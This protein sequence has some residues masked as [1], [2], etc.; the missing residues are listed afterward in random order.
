MKSNIGHTSAAAGVAGVIKMVL[1]LQHG[2]LPKTLHLG[3]PSRHVDWSAGAVELLREARP[4]R[5]NG[6][7][8]R[9]GVSAFGVSGTN[10]HVILEEAPGL[11]EPG[12][13]EVGDSASLDGEGGWCVWAFAELGVLPLLVS[14]KSEV[15]LGAQAQRLGARLRKDPELASLDVAF[16]LV[17]GRAQLER[18]AVVVGGDRERL[19]AG[20]DA[21]ACDKPVEGLV[22]GVARD[23]GG[24]VFVFSGQG[25]QWGGMALGLWESSAVF[26]AE[27]DAC[28][29]AF[30]PYLGF[31][32]EDVLRGREGASVFERVDVLQPAL[33]AVMV[34]LAAL[35]RSCG[36][37]PGAVVGHSQ[38]EIAAAYV[39]GGLSLEDAACVVALRGRALAD[40]LSGRGGMVSVAL[41]VDEVGS[42][43]EP[44]GERVAL[45]AVNGPSSVVISGEP[46]AL[47]E[48]LLLCETRGLRAKQ[49]PVDYASHSR[50]V[51]VI[52]GRLEE[53]LA[54]DQPALW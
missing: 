33:F 29:R 32:L 50:Q 2:V 46:E 38:G 42:L 12:P 14:A 15:A 28:V 22:R 48:L 17:G 52:Q 51:E 44:F 47:G 49:I 18:R 34:S 41:G 23:R 43:L 21:L 16:S 27:M 3:E 25:C 11:P 37:V 9:A 45:A 10:A 53:E 36:V 19:L 39:A 30:A 20:L 40:E 6:R 35:W 26:A 54:E 31:S 1:A 24:V 8:R 4:W 13:A 5:A 7:P